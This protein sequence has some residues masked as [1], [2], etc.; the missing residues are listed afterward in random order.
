[1]A[2]TSPTELLPPE[3]FPD[4][5]T[6][7]NGNAMRVHGRSKGQVEFYQDSRS[8]LR[9]RCVFF[10]LAVFIIA[11]AVMTGLFAWRMISFRETKTGKVSQFL[12]YINTV[13]E[14]NQPLTGFLGSSAVAQCYATKMF[15]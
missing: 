4:D 1:M 5:I 2:M 9:F 12:P 11:T 13:V 3:V 6:D 15:M 14:R 10:A 8:R 7:L